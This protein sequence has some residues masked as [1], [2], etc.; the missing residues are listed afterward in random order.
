MKKDDGVLDEPALKEFW[1]PIKLAALKHFSSKAVGSD[2]KTVEYTLRQEISKRFTSFQK[3]C[4][5]RCE[6]SC[7]KLI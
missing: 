5:A 4:L 7:K 2:F 6:D 3:L 1:K